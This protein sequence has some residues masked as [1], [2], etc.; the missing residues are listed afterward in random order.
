VPLSV[1]TAVPGG[2]MVRP[3]NVPVKNTVSVSGAAAVG[4]KLAQSTFTGPLM[5]GGNP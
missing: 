4:V 5:I 2:V 1:N 3:L